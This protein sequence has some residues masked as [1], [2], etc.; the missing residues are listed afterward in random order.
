MTRRNNFST[1]AWLLLGNRN[2]PGELRLSSGRLSFCVLGEG[3]LGRRGFEKLEARSGCAELGAL[4]ERGARPLLFELPLSEVERVHFPWYYFSGGLK[5]TI[6]GV[7]YRFGFD[8][9]SNS[10]GVNEGG[11]LFGSIARA[12]RAGKAWKAVFEEGS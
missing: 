3:N 8:Q 11:D 5:L 6:A 1:K 7:Q 4:V 2:L 12:R 10:R 9:P